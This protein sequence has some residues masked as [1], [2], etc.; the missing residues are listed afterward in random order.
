MVSEKF[1]LIAAFLVISL[2]GNLRGEENDAGEATF[3]TASAPH[4]GTIVR[5]VAV[6][7]NAEHFTEAARAA[8]RQ[9]EKIEQI[10]SDYRPDSEI[11]QLSAKSHTKSPVPVS[12]QLWQVLQRAQAVHSASGG[13]FDPTVGPLTKQWRRFRRRKELDPDRIERSLSAVGMRH[14]VLHP[15]IQAVSLHTADM[16]IDLGGIAKGYALDAALATLREMGI[17]RALV[18]AGGDLAFGAAPRGEPGWRVGIAGL[19]P[20]QPPLLVSMLSHAAVA[21]S[22]DAYQFLEIDGKR[23]SHILNPRTGYGVPHRGTVPVFAENA[24]EADAWASALSVLGPEGAP[25][26]L[27]EQ[28]E[29]AVWMEFLQDERPFTWVSPNLGGWLAEHTSDADSAAD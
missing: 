13:A 9:I 8:F 3:H 6:C 18:D 14:V 19:D 2:G 27:Q 17:D 24:T 21:T 15:E 5:I 1:L 26:V 11:L 23:Y 4:L 22:G 10:C 7:D 29:L 20:R 12:D 28:S 16:R 25:Q